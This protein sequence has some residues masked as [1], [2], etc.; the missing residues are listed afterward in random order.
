MILCAYHLVY[1]NICAAEDP[2]FETF[3]TKN[4]LLNAGIHAWM[5]AQYQP[6]DNLIFPGEIRPHRN[7][8]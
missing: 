7:A 3:H 6:H 8:L 2:K 1:P 5:A 4:I